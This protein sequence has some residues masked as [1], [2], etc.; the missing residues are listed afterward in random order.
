MEFMID[1][2][3]DEDWEQVRSIYVDGIATGEATFE[4]RAPDWDAWNES[5]LTFG[6]IVARC[7]GAVIGWAALTPVSDRCAYSGVAEVS[8]YVSPEW[9]GR[10]VGGSLLEALI[11]ASEKNDIWTLQA[12]VFP[13]NHAS[14][15]LHRGHG[16]REVGRRER[17]GKLNGAWRDVM[18]LE[19]RSKQVGV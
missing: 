12:G 17:L 6:R 14:V 1:K 11:I 18:L 2:M 3:R 13:E 15:E 19:R 16:F 5:H 4:T 8:V 7:G 10:G 9:R